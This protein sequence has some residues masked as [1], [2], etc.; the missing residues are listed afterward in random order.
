MIYAKSN[1]MKQM[2]LKLPRWGGK[3]RGAGRKPNG[4]KA[5]IWH[6]SR[7]RVRRGPVH[8]NWHMRAGTWNLRQFKCFKVIAEA[9]AK[10]RD[11]FGMRII[12]FSVQGNH[13]HLIVEADDTGSLSKGM[14]GLGVRIA[15][16]LNRVMKKRGKRLA[17]RYHAHV[18]RTPAE[19]RN[20]VHYVL[21]NHLK[22]HDLAQKSK[23]DEFSSESFPTPT[24]APVTWLMKNCGP[25]G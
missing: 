23:R 10:A 16:A 24:T 5:G 22:H 12:H 6:V 4:A 17:D 25:S 9:F 1:L 20:A 8:V 14:Q 2:T 3:R 11:R 15:R 21:R 7:A 18:L 13:L 19:V